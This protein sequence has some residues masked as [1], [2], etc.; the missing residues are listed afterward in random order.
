M[1]CEAVGAPVENFR[2]EAPEWR[3]VRSTDQPEPVVHVVGRPSAPMVSK[4]PFTAAVGPRLIGGNVVRSPGM[5]L[6]CATT[7]I[8]MSTARALRRTT[9]RGRIID[10]QSSGGLRGKE[11]LRRY[12]QIPERG[13]AIYLGMRT[14][15]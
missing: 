12:D 1:D 4:P 2:L 10:L 9:R 14:Y 6:L 15:V 5:G 13:W 3:V 7:C 11:M 8:G